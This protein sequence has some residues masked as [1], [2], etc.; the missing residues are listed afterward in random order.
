MKRNL[1]VAAIILSFFI[2]SSANSEEHDSEHSTL[3][4][5]PR[6]ES[7]QKSIDHALAAMGDNYHAR[8]EHLD[9]NGHPKQG[10][11]GQVLNSEST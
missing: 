1:S 8:T 6:T 3:S 4:F 5:V 11:L 2:F 9:S 10:P 7:L